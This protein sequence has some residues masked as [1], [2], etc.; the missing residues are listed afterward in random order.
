[1]NLMLMLMVQ[2]HAE[3]IATPEYK[4]ATTS[5]AK[6]EHFISGSMGTNAP[7]F[8]IHYNSRDTEAQ[9]EIGSESFK[10]IR[11]GNELV[12]SKLIGDKET[13]YRLL[14]APKLEK[15]NRN[16][17]FAIPNSAS[18]IG[19]R[20]EKSMILI[21]ESPRKPTLFEDPTLG[22]ME[23][24]VS[25]LAPE[26]IERGSAT[27]SGQN[28]T[29]DKKFSGSLGKNQPNITVAYNS[30]GIDA[31]IQIGD[32]KFSGI[33]D[34]K[35]IKFSKFENGTTVTY[36]LD[37]KPSFQRTNDIFFY[38]KPEGGSVGCSNERNLVLMETSPGTPT[39]LDPNPSNETQIYCINW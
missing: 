5:A 11:Q 27:A 7:T 30:T 20:T 10:A 2:L 13:K 3:T 14:L 17:W 15:E 18:R 36:Q 35:S 6:F 31:T 32:E 4:A 19:C 38:R 24:D 29:Y 1:M 12:F 8:A 37:L 26:R 23:T 34:G 21:Q 39:M 22:P 33:R 9:V 16:F 25:C 28:S